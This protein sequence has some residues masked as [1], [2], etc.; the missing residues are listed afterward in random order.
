[1]S[2]LVMNKQGGYSRMSY[3]SYMGRVL[4]CD[5]S[6]KM[7]DLVTIHVLQEHRSQVKL[8]VVI[9]ISTNLK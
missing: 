3:K 9:S 6:W 5:N 1:M 8:N 7:A 2:G 4:L